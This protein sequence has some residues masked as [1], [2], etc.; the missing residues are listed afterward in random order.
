MSFAVFRICVLLKPR[1]S[2]TS[3]RVVGRIADNIS[4]EITAQNKQTVFEQTVDAASNL[5]YNT[6]SSYVEVLT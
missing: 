1:H 6:Y 5:G 2:A 4:K 3:R